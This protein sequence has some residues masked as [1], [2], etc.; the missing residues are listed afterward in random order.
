MNT[1]FVHRWPDCCDEL[2]GDHLEPNV[3]YHDR[4]DPE[5]SATF[6]M[7]LEIHL[8]LLENIEVLSTYSLG[9]AVLAHL[10]KELSEATKPNRAKIACCIHLLQIWV[11]EHIHVGRPSELSK[12]D[13]LR[14]NGMRNGRG[15]TSKKCRHVQG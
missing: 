3:L 5:V 4:A 11:L 2:L 14:T 13:I 7:G 15:K 9:S 6:R 10:Y 1:P 8:Q 12:Y